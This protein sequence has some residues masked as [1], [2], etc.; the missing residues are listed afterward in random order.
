MAL[1]SKKEIPEDQAVMM[2][3]PRAVFQEMLNHT[4]KEWPA[5]CCGLLA[6]RDW[7]VTRIYPLENRDGS[8]VSY[9][10]DP[11]QQLRAFREMEDLRLDLLAIYH[12]HPHTE[13]YPSVVDMEK[14]C[15]PEALYVIISL[16]DPAG[17]VRAFR[18]TRPGK[19]TQAMFQVL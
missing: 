4:R 14:A 16:K 8:S 1:L 13:G 15:Y 5:E 17:Q 19:V 6:G 9:R 3:I 7:L 12:S 18:M 10:A 2:R 11:H